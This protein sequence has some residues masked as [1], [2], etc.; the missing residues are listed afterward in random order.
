MP[1]GIAPER[2]QAA[3]T[4]ARSAAAA[5]AGFTMSVEGEQASGRDAFGAALAGACGRSLLEL[6]GSHEQAASAVPAA[7]RFARFTG[8]LVH[9]R[10][11]GA[12]D[13]VAAAALSAAVSGGALTVV[14]AARLAATAAD[15][16]VTL[17]P[18]GLAARRSLWSRALAGEGVVAGDDVLDAVA[19]RFRLDAGQIAAAAARAAAEHRLA[20]DGA[21]LAGAAL[22]S[23]ARAQQSGT[24]LERLARRIIPTRT[25]TDL[26]LA[27][28]PGGQVRELCAWIR[29]RGVVHDAWGFGRKLGAARGLNALF[30]GPPGT[31][32]TL[33]AEV[34]ADEVGLDLYRIDLASVVSKFI[35]ETEKNLARVFDEARDTNAILL[36]DE[37]DALFG[38]RSE[39]R[40]AHDR[41]ANIE[42]SYL[43]QR[44]EEHDGVSLLTTNRRRDLDEAF[45]RRLQFAIDFSL[46][47]AA[48]RAQIWGAIWPAQTPLA[49]DVDLKVVADRFALSGGHIRNIAEAAAFLAATDGGAVTMRHLMAAARREYRKLGTLLTA[50][51]FDF[52]QPQL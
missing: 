26:V 8:A 44:M 9:V 45:V 6:D 28:E 21:E 25:W 49:D 15:V 43:L 2:W 36:F 47:D 19:Q 50:G 52:S 40:D 41:Y 48:Q 31:G 24:G 1:D 30:A 37:A 13:G 38:K 17:T 33:S 4:L 7:F 12:Q 29:H 20:G 35:G 27:D 10:D 5:G 11:A 32:K 14:S 18:P 3:A 46:P 16:H 39:V 51:E 42:I 23:A 34:I 22:F